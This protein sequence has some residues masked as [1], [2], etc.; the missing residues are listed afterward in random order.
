[1]PAEVTALIDF[2]ANNGLGVGIALF[3]V[4]AVIRGWLVP[5]FIYR[6]TVQRLDA[7]LAANASNA[8][9]T[10]RLTNAVLGRRDA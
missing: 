10:D 9:A 5:G 3:L 8:A 6:D 4:V 2:V 7:S 1:M